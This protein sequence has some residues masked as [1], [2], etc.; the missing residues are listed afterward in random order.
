MFKSAHLTASISRKAGGLFD[1][2]QRL[3]QARA[4][5]GEDVK[6]FGV[7][8]EFAEADL[9]SWK[10]VSALAFTPSWPKVIGRSPRFLEE[11]TAFEPD[12][13]HTHGI[14]LYPSVATKNYSRTGKRPYLISP[15]GMLDPWAMNHSRWKKKIAWALFE[16]DHLRG[17]NCLRALCASEAQSIR[18]LGLKN[19]IAIIPNGID[20]PQNEKA[21]IL[22]AETLKADKIKTADHDLRI[23]TCG[24]DQVL[25]AERLKTEMLKN[26]ANAPWEGYVEPG[27]K[28]L[29]FLSRIHPKKGLVNLLKAWEEDRRWKM[30]DGR[31]DEWVLAIAGWEQGGHE[32]E[33]KRLCSELQ[34]PFADIREPKSVV[35]GPWSVVFLG[36]QFNAA[37][38]ACYR[39]CDAFVLPSFSEGLPMVVLEAWA[40]SKPVIM[41][42]ECN[43]PEGFQAAAALRAEATEAG[44]LSGLRELQRMTDSE[45]LAMGTR[46]R[47]LVEERFTWERVGEQLR[48]VQE[49]ILGGGAKPECVR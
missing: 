14:W 21:E 31:S 22:K 23:T 9:P 29:L 46:A 39:N 25:Q 30:E 20:L 5:Q 48:A 37:K 33:L 44:I 8:D 24:P 34:I 2:V 12:I 43:L 36:P 7:W 28:V 42:P 40:H 47:R 4:G 26:G 10:P 41:T 13:C 19:D 32:A 49:W 6:V 17:A 18:Q 38:A 1:A 45:R 15:H 11:L 35:R 16:R 3:V 27:K